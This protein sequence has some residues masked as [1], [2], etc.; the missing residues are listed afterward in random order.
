MSL[1]QSRLNEGSETSIL[2]C[3]KHLENNQVNI[4]SVCSFV[5]LQN[6]TTE[7]RHG[8]NDKATFSWAP[9]AVLLRLLFPRAY[10]SQRA[11][12]NNQR[13][14]PAYVSDSKTYV[15][16]IYG[17]RPAYVS[18]CK[19]YVQNIHGTCPANVSDC[20][21]Y[22]QNIHGTCPAYVSVRTTYVHNIYGTCPAYVS[23]CKTYVQNVH[24]IL[25]AA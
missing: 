23:D 3:N 14:Y 7:V 5:S 9:L 25:L 4:D 20:K 2:P 1:V 15:H 13:I 11:V 22:V 24:N 17:T 16:N 21:T 10:T 12:F 18:D 19:T 6:R 8:C